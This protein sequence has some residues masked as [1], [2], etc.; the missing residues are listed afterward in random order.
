MAIK[1]YTTSIDPSK[2]VGEIQAILAKAWHHWIFE[3]P[4]A[5]VRF[6]KGR[7]KFGGGNERCSISVCGDR[8]QNSAPFPSAVVIFDRE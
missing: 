2:T 3:N 5:T 4:N 1:N 6:V 8:I 7:L